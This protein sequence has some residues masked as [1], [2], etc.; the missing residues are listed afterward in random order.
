[1]IMKKSALVS[2]SWLAKLSISRR[3]NLQAVAA[4]LLSV[5]II[6]T[7][8]VG[9][10]ISRDM[11]VKADEKNEAALYSALLEK[12]FASLERDAFRHALLLSSESEAN[13]EG[14]LA[15]MRASLEETREKMDPTDLP[16]ADA[17][18]RTLDA[19]EQTV[20]QVIAEGSPGTTAVAR[21]VD[22]GNEVD[23]AIEAFRDPAILRASEFSIEQHA[24]ANIVMIITSLIAVIAGL[25]SFV[26]AR[27][28]RNAI[29]REL[30]GV[31]QSIAAIE[32]GELDIQIDHVE[33]T[34]ELGEL[35]RAAERLRDTTKEKVQSDADMKRMVELVSDRLQRMADGDL[36]V[37]LPELGANYA[38]LRTDFNRTV[39]Q[40]REAIESVNVS[41]RDIRTGSVEISQASNDLAKRTERNAG[42]LSKATET[43]TAISESLRDTTKVSAEANHGVEQAV[44]EARQGGQIVSKAVDAMDK[45][46]RST[47]EIASIIMTID[48]I[49]FQTNLLALHAA[50]EA[51]RAGEV[52]KAFA[53]VA[54]EVRQLARRSSEAAQDIRGLIENSSKEV[55]SGVEMVSETGKALDR[56]IERVSSVTEMVNHIS[57]ASAKQSGDLTQSNETMLTMDQMTQQNAAMV[58]QTSAAAHNLASAADTL[59]GL[60]A[61]FRLNTDAHSG[62]VR[63]D[64]LA[65][66]STSGNLL[67]VA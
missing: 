56:I 47:S 18:G 16:L 40:L 38:G 33:R 8:V 14:N 7:V 55:A 3:L 34:D 48:G 17:V 37:E 6:A 63:E 54:E 23:T 52:G 67:L 65:G 10:I 45:I 19:Y 35:A 57:E 41:A 1:M 59:S 31:Q 53:V 64:R 13:Y 28:I 61:Q 9:S 12:D 66:H 26:M 32:S 21:I 46:E 25:V 15:D 58:E 36:S 62:P 43:V 24:L 39:T 11:L 30:A 42:E 5:A 49:A 51:A 50:V 29:V 44:K 27:A 4:G 2:S 22:S 60:V 20:S